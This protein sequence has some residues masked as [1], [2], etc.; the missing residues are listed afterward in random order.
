MVTTYNQVAGRSLERIAALSDGL[1]A[2]AMTLIVLDI[3]LPEFSSIHSEGE[4]VSA[5]WSMAPRMVTYLMSF[6]TLGIFWVGQ[7]VQ[8]SHLEKSDRHLTW[9]HLL[10]L[11]VVALIPLSTRLLAGF[12]GY[13]TALLLY[14]ANLLLL[15]IVIYACWG[16]AC[17]AKLVKKEA[18]K[19]AYSLLQRRIISAQALYAFGASLCFFDTA[20]SIGFIVLIQLNYAIAPRIP[21]LSK[22]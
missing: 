8:L 13:R 7:Q 2:F 1:F 6:L 14:W 15:G 4:L 18:M 12:I 10:Y 19:G 11:A 9:L 20:W 21:F 16:Y 22:L 3:R 5:L 17:K